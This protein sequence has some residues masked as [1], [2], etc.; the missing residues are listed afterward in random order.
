MQ[1]LIAAELELI[2]GVSWEAGLGPFLVFG[3]GGIHTEIL[4][5]VQLAPIPTSRATLRTQIAAS[6]TGRLLN[7]VASEPEAIL[8]QLADA[9][10]ALQSAALAAGERIASIDV[11]PLVVRGPQLVAVDALVVLR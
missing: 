10:D 2:A 1:P 9:L 7:A 11:N 3:L 4:D 5:D 8:E 6:R